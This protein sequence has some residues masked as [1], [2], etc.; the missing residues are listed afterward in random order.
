MADAGHTLDLANLTFSAGRGGEAG[1][2]RGWALRSDVDGFTNSIDTQDVPTTRPVFTDFQV[3]LS[4][5]GFQNLTEVTF[6]IYTYVDGGG[7]SV[8]YDFITING[9]VQ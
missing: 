5:P 9:T 3:D 8:D 6:R 1:L 4:G 7:R 2:P